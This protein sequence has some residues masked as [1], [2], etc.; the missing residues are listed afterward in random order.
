MQLVLNDNVHTLYLS[1]SQDI[2][3]YQTDQPL[4]EVP[5]VPLYIL[6]FPRY[7]PDHRHRKFNYRIRYTP[8]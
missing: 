8:R 4:Y 1:N 6:E 5:R 3:D 7:L 2:P